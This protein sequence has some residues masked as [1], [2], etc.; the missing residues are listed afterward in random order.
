MDKVSTVTLIAE[1]ETLDELRQPVMTE[2]PRTVYC[3]ELEITRSEWSAASQRSIRA[4]HVLKVF[5]YDYNGEQLAE[6]NGKR[7]AIYRTYGIGDYIELYLGEK[8]GDLNG[9]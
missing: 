3:T 9:G 2:T 6:F 7:L 5:S 8:V 4:D 1:T